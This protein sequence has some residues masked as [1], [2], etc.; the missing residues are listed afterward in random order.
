VREKQKTYQF[1]A[2]AVSQVAGG[3]ARAS[4]RSRYYAARAGGFA[5]GD[6]LREFCH[7]PRVKTAIRLTGG[8]VL[9]KHI[10]CV[11]VMIATIMT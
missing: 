9:R 10:R 7:L 1:A 3:G 8:G 4:E 11:P 6:P 5:G 2:E